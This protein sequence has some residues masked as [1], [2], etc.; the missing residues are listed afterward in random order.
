MEEEPGSY[1]GL[2]KIW[3]VTACSGALTVYLSGR[4]RGT[5]SP[6]EQGKG[7]LWK[8]NQCP[9]LPTFLFKML[10]VQHH[11]VEGG[12]FGEEVIS[13]PAWLGFAALLTARCE[14]TE[15]I[16]KDCEQLD[17][18]AGLFL[19]EGKIPSERK[20]NF[21]S[22]GAT[23]RQHLPHAN[24]CSHNLLQ[25]EKS[26]G[27]SKNQTD[28][29]QDPLLALAHSGLVTLAKSLLSLVFLFVMGRGEPVAF[30]KRSRSKNKLVLRTVTS[31]WK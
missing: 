10:L 25:P 14:R 5:N 1:E 19:A 4:E 31:C 27:W 28:K 8:N 17:C 7:G 2:P 6:Y 21:V 29:V 20:R 13:N 16:Y 22:G 3:G 15:L 23:S 9:T 12:W 18:G 24:T 26:E 11:L 30:V